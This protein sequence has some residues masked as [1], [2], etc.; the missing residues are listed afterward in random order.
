[1]VLLSSM[2][3]LR[4]LVLTGVRS[5]TGVFIMF[6]SAGFHQNR[7]LSSQSRLAQIPSENFF[8]HGDEYDAWDFLI[9]LVFG[10]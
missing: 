1:M 4:Y 6:A 5:I 3:L 2:V 10:N 8:P 7:E 9:N